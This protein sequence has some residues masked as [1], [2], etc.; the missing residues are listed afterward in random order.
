VRYKLSAYSNSDFCKIF[1]L[2]TF[3]KTLS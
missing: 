1:L 2:A 3:I